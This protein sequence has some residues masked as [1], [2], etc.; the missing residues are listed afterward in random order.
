[1]NEERS[2]VVCGA[3]L[4][5]LVAARRLAAAGADVTVYEQR[6]TV[7]GRVRSREREGFTLDRGFQVLFTA[8]PAVRRELDLDALDLRPFSPG[9]VIAREGE[10]S[11]LSDPLR[12]P[13]SVFESLFN[14]EVTTSDKLRTLALR[15]DLA[16]KPL[17]ALFRGPDTTIEEYL[18]DWGFSSRFAENFVAPFYGGITLDRSLSTSKRVFEYTFRMLSDGR[19]AVPADG[20]GAIADQ[21]A[22]R[23]EAVGV[24]IHTDSV[25]YEVSGDA[26]GAT[27]DVDGATVEADAVV[28]GTD[29]RTAAELTDVDAIPT[30]ARPSTTQYY[31]LPEGT[32]LGTKKRILLNAESATPNAVVPLSAV[33]PEYAP[34]DAELLNATFLGETPLSMDDEALADATRDALAAWY[35]ERQFGALE[36]IATD[37][38]EFAQFDQPPGIHDSL[39]DVR[40]PAGRVYLAGD[41]TQ[42][43][44]IQGAL[45]SG[46]VAAQAVGDDF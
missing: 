19:T 4:A 14:R 37:R 41:Y 5:G 44:S 17:D 10:R 1:M 31:R 12:D 24:D 30:R 33:A 45:E 21:L 23:A 39:P 43:S 16:S 9:A 40:A 34:D 46:R 2:V 7:G 8:Y 18:S 3:G 38:I 22:D 6:E 20:M 27:L 15:Q 35:P 28:V 29:P 36:P 32:D 13:F 42:W 11:V 25:V 26:D